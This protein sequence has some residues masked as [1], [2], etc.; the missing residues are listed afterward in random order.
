MSK[1]IL[2]SPGIYEHAA[3]LI[4]ERPWTVSRNAELLYQAQRSA[5]EC[6]RHPFLVAGIDVYDVEPEA[7]GAVVG[8]PAGNGV[9]V[10]VSHP[11]PSVAELQQTR[12]P[13]PRN[14]GRMPLVLEVASRLRQDLPDADVFVPICGPLAFACALAGMDEILCSM[15]DEPGA[16]TRAL[17]HLAEIQQPFI[18]AINSVGARPLIF[19]S[20]ATPPLLPRNLFP[21]IEAPALGRLFSMC[22]GSSAPCCIIGGDVFPVVGEIAALDP[23]FLIC[24]SETN[25][26]AFVDF[27][28]SRPEIAVRV[29]MPV[30]AVLDF[31]WNVTR[32]AADQAIALAKRLAAGSVG[33]GVIPVDADPERLIRLRSYIEENRN[34]SGNL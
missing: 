20:G 33:A 28:H 18:Q 16:V 10:V 7:L 29:N 17:L 4:G 12:P 15:M 23:G 21:S 32:Q 30:T 1:P 11:F 19:E 5:W 34:L 22:R 14:D 24:P 2:F 26:S 25:Q 3:A 31:D 8:E 27:L 13:D 6:Y 9:P